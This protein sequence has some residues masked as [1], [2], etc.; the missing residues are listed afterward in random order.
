MNTKIVTTLTAALLALPCL[1]ADENEAKPVPPAGGEA[2]E[3]TSRPARPERGE[4]IKRF[5]KDGDG[6]LNEDERKAAQE[7]MRKRFGGGAPGGAPGAGGAEGM[8]KLL[9]NPGPRILERYDADKDGKLSDEEK[10]KAREEMKGRFDQGRGD[11]LKRFD[12]DGDGKLSDEE[13]KQGME[14]MRKRFRDGGGEGAEGEA[15]RQRLRERFDTNKD[16]QIDE[17]ERA[18]M[19][20]ARQAGSEDS[21]KPV[22][23]KD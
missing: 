21:A 13:R 9:E 17:G 14:E 6:K 12:K 10:K 3:Q 8:E 11:M 15:M 22:E 18:K 19:R 5:D 7:E 16:G 23:K 2:K 20:E 1:A 4:I